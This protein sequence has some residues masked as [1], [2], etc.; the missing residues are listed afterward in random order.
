M[1]RYRQELVLEEHRILVVASLEDPRAGEEFLVTPAMALVSLATQ[2]TADAEF[3][4]SPARDPELRVL[5]A[6][7][8]AFGALHQRAMECAELLQQRVEWA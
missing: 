7:L 8:P 3:L 1:I 4:A 2:S 6:K 5:P